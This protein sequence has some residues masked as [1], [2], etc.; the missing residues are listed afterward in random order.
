MNDLTKS[1]GHIDPATHPSFVRLREQAGFETLNE[2]N[3]D[4]F[5]ATEG[6]KMAIFADDPNS[7]KET[8]DIIVIAPE[9]QKSF[10]GT[11]SQ[12]ALADF[13]VARALAARWGLR[14]MPALALF[15]DQDFLG[16]VQGL[17]SWDGYCQKLVE[18]LQTKRSAPRVIAILNKDAEN[19]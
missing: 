1:I 2:A 7:R 8:L 6:L 17:Q 11:L 9:L 5:L 13:A 19:A 14:S 12:C 18:I 15:M 16:A 4:A 10:N 3:I